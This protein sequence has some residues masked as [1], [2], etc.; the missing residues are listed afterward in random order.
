MTGDLKRRILVIDG[1]MGTMIQKRNLAEEDFR[2]DRFRDIRVPL[3]GNNDILNITR[4]D[5]IRAIHD[6]YIRSGADIITTNTFSSNR[7]SQQD[8][9]CEDMAAE[10]A[11]QGARIARQAADACTERKIWVAGSVGPTNKTLSMASDVNHPEERDVDFGTMEEAYREQAEALIEGG[12]DVILAETCF[13]ALNTKALIAALSE[14]SDT[15][16][17]LMISATVN[18]RSGRTL[19]GQTLEA[20]FVSVS[21]YPL[22]SFGLNCSMGAEDL[23]PFTRRLAAELPVYISL[24][25]NAGLPNEMGEYDEQ[26]EDTACHIGRLASSGDINIAG[27]C[28]GTTPQHIAS[29][30]RHIEGVQ[31]RRPKEND[32][33][34]RVS[35]LEPLTI[36]RDTSNFI[37]IGERTNVAGS[38]KFARLIAEKNYDEAAGVARK[39]IEGGASIIDVNMDD[40]MLDSRR[41]M[42]TF[43]RYIA[44]DPAI[45]RVPVMIDSSDWD[46]IIEGLENCQG[47]CIVNSISLKN[48]EDDFLRKARQLRRYGA[49]VVVMAFDEEGQATSY[50]RKTAIARRSYDLLTQQA[51]FPPEDIIFD[52]NILSVGTGIEEHA[53][54]GID[55][56][57]AVKWIKENLPYAKTSGGLSNLSFA[58]RG[59]N[60]VREAMHSVFLYHA[61]QAG[62]DMAI[63]NPSMIQVYDDIDPELRQ[64]AEDVI[65]NRGEGATERLIALAADIK[66]RET[67]EGGKTTVAAADNREGMT[68]AGK[69]ADDLIKG[70]TSNIESDI[71]QALEEAGGQ[72][73]KVIE[74]PLMDGMERVGAL[75]GEGKMFLPQVV[76]AAKVMKEAV[77]VLQP[78]IEDSDSQ[79]SSSSRPKIVIATVKGDVHDI[80][81]NIV[82]IV[83]ACNNFEVVDLGVM[84]DAETIMTTAV[85]EKALMVGVSGL[86]T[87]SLKEMENLCR[88]FQEHHQNIPIFVGGATTSALHTA[89]KLA[90][91]YSGGVIYGGDASATSVIAKRFLSDGRKVIEEVKRQQEEQRQTYQNK[92]TP[93]CSF[94]EADAA[95]PHYAAAPLP[96]VET[97]ETLRFDLQDLE[98]AIDWRMLLYFWGFRGASAEEV[99]AIPEAAA[100]LSDAKELFAKIKN[101]NSISAEAA[102]LLCDARR[103]GNDIILADGTTLPMLRSQKPGDSI[104]LAD[105][106]PSAE[107]KKDGCYTPAALF[108]V[109]AKDKSTADDRYESLMRYALA[110]R[111]AEAATE[112]L[113][114]TVRSRFAAAGASD[115]NII[116][117][118]FGYPVCPDHSLKKIV[119]D[120]LDCSRLGISITDS[121]ALRPS[122]TTCGM[123][124]FHPEA[125][126]FSVG[127]IS[128]KQLSDYCRRRGISVDEGRKLLSSLL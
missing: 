124:I 110:A 85:R 98:A 61:I 43:L 31:P 55:F 118:A 16:F 49:A 104:S 5:V 100:T 27:G 30:R 126:Y 78:Y 19:T 83:L 89:V 46:T 13:D 48:G 8:Y 112:R 77:A 35:G 109:T 14:I 119:F 108:C 36:D 99:L 122:T 2:G 93:I 121:Y 105:F 21:H 67:A 44:N 114:Q 52:C 33:L 116:R 9:G 38:R 69:L 102:I 4:P 91:L 29:I 25:P 41:E 101:D 90:P 15:P 74:G 11:L 111:I 117:P 70:D 106:L 86:I 115:I 10:M 63:M 57:R 66:A 59:N 64:C 87:P 12:V 81:K 6:E 32:H 34:L 18:D 1:A 47:K 60:T 65:L 58:F 40:A 128:E 39:Q 84:V 42:R 123:M 68:T 53:R 28:C 94:A 125:H 95:A 56:I 80:G 127:R 120:R 23:E 92:N 96:R 17:P 62:L 113:E 37:N 76:K 26:P 3:K 97:D 7:I 75:F 73:V 51:A 71:M 82:G 24:Y 20:F 45:T 79:V 50:E 54:Y 22:V 107:E 88:L 103:Q 72:A